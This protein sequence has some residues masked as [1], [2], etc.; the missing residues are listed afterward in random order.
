MRVSKNSRWKNVSRNIKTK[1]PLAIQIML[2]S[3]TNTHTGTKFYLLQTKYEVGRK[4]CSFL[5]ENDVSISRKHA[6]I[7]VQMVLFYA[8]E[9]FHAVF[10][11]MQSKQIN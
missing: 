9:Y 8:F 11:L 7:E 4:N 10:N 3:L 6:V 1:L 2:F 5:I